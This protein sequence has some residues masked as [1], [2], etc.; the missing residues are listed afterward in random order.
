MFRY[1]P[2]VAILAGLFPMAVAQTPDAAE[3]ADNYLVGSLS[4]NL[5]SGLNWTVLVDNNTSNPAIIDDIRIGDASAVSGGSGLM[6]TSGRAFILEG[7]SDGSGSTLDQDGVSLSF[8]LDPSVT[9]ADG[10]D[11]RFVY[12]RVGTGNFGGQAGAI[13]S[14]DSSG[15]AL[16][17]DSSDSNWRMIS[18]GSTI[19]SSIPS[20][21]PTEFLFTKNG[22][23]FDYRI[24]DLSNSATE[25]GTLTPFTA[26]NLVSVSFNFLMDPSQVSD[27]TMLI[28]EVE[29][30][31]AGG[32]PVELD[33]FV[34]E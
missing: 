10:A 19:T 33:G 3:Y 4:A 21:N 17:V 31:T 11:L 9:L 23:T 14:N 18:S 8:E 30:A 1:I 7:A 22:G 6:N 24:R 25:S 20:S 15:L 5:S 29:F 27:N 28:N 26:G 2:H 13:L 34:V 12:Q 16:I 32:L